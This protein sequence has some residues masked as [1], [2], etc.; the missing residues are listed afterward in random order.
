M[1]FLSVIPEQVES[2]PAIWRHSLSAEP[3]SYAAAAGPHNSGARRVTRCR[4][5][6]CRYSAPTVGSA[7][8]SAQASAFHDEP[9]QPAENWRDC[10]PQHRIPRQRP[11]QRAECSERTGPIVA[12][13]TPS[14][15]ESAELRPQR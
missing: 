9:R 7:R 15:A 4:P 14:A 13:V 2:A 10:I 12:S 11:K 5:R 3:A 6:L 1:Q 8:F